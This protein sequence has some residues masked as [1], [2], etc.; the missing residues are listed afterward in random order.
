MAAARSANGVA[1]IPESP[2]RLAALGVG[3]K[4]RSPVHGVVLG[5]AC[6]MVLLVVA[7]V[8]AAG[9]LRVR[10]TEAGVE[11]RQLRTRLYPWK[12][13]AA[14]QLT[15]ERDQIELVLLTQALHPRT[16]TEILPLPRGGGRRPSDATLRDAVAAIE[17]R[18][19]PS[20]L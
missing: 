16:Q 6:R 17:R 12:Q 18:I 2:A 9:R 13:T 5:R 14:A 20:E 8:W 11:V 19:K 3:S 4:E 1:G 7:G 15:P 10:L